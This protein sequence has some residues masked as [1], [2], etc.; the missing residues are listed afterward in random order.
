L[1][2]DAAEAVSLR[3]CQPPLDARSSRHQNNSGRGEPE[4]D[5]Q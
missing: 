3:R 1:K 5:L 4:M 2:A